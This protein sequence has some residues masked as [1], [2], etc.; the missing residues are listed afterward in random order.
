MVR[1]SLLFIAAVAA[2]ALPALALG[3]GPTEIQV[4]DNSFSP[5]TPPLRGFQTGASFHWQRAASS[6][7]SH[8]I[9][10]DA[11]LFRSGNPT[12]GAINYTISASAGSYHYYCDIHGSP[13]GGMTGV[14]KVRP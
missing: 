13:A 1:R 8:N 5:K 9:H 2:F 12:A 11:G 4:K 14:I 7:G 3:A 10:Q 6:I